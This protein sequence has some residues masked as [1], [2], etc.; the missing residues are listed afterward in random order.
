MEY[1]WRYQNEIFMSLLTERPVD[2]NFFLK[3]L[4]KSSAANAV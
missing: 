4:S 1:I 2:K 3:N